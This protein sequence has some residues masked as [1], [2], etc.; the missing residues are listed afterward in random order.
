MLILVSLMNRNKY[1]RI[2]SIIGGNEGWEEDINRRKR[3]TL[4]RKNRALRKID[5]V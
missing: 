2:S 4:I 3:R 5:I 1:S